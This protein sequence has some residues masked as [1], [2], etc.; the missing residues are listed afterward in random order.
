MNF[1]A[2]L[3]MGA[4]VALSIFGLLMLLGLFK[5]FDKTE[6]LEL[7]L[8]LIVMSIAC[9]PAWGL[10]YAFGCVIFFKTTKHP[11]RQ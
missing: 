11:S 8:G 2:F 6:R 5:S 9:G 4:I 1:L 3:H 10:F 7:G